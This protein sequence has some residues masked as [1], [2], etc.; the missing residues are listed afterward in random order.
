MSS[1]VFVLRKRYAEY[2]MTMTHK[3]YKFLD[4][5]EKRPDGSLSTK[6]PIEINGVGFAAGTLFVRGVL[7]G[8]IDFYMYETKEIAVETEE[9]SESSVFRIVGFV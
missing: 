7:Y 6:V 2:I 5:F 4:I 9:E 1:V 8:G 3:N